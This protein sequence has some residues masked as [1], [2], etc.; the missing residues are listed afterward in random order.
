MRSHILLQQY[1]EEKC[2]STLKRKV[3]KVGKMEFQNIIEYG[4]IQLQDAIVQF[5]KNRNGKGRETAI[6]G[7][8]LDQL[9]F[10][11]DNVINKCFFKHNLTIFTGKKATV[12]GYFRP[13]KNWDLVVRNGND[14]IAA[15]E[16]K[17]LV[18]SHGNNYNNRV[19]ECLGCSVDLKKYFEHANKPCPFLGYLLVIND[20]ECTQRKR[21]NCKV[22]MD[23]F[24]D[25]GYIDRKR[26]EC[27]ELVN[28]DIYHSA[29]L[30]EFTPSD[31]DDHDNVQV[32]YKG[33]SIFLNKLVN[34]IHTNL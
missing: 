8:S 23:K 7:T 2:E 5:L 20:E 32:N 11:I 15:I 16:L 19:E 6:K 24:I 33:F 17:S 34:H 3:E 14:I 1:S 13:S 21:R 22:M 27:E 12:P 10:I 29:Q 4:I 30:V 31:Q 26:I 9:V 25:T 28:E 18:R